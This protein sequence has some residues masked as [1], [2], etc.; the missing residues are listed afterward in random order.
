MLRDLRLGFS[1]DCCQDDIWYDVD[2]HGF[3]SGLDLRIPITG[4]PCPE[5]DQLYVIHHQCSRQSISRNSWAWEGVMSDVI[6][7][8]LLLAVVVIFY[9]FWKMKTRKHDQEE[10]EPNILS[11]QYWIW[12]KT[13]KKEQAQWDNESEQER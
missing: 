2:V 8:F 7:Y 3:N 11:L 1:E 12:R 4:V 13:K 5:P 9:L 6:L 10:E